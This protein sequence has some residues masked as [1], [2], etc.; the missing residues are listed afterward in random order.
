[1]LQALTSSLGE[2]MRRP[3]VNIS[4]TK[5]QVEGIQQIHLNTGRVWGKTYTIPAARYS[6]PLTWCCPLS[7]TRHDQ[8]LGQHQEDSRLASLSLVGLNFPQFKESI[9][10]WTKP[11]H[12]KLKKKTFNDMK[13]HDVKLIESIKLKK[14]TEG[15]MLLMKACLWYC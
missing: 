7:W 5:S 12:P 6:N 14:Y 1:M 15:V 4:D 8:V 9:N 10:K 11:K 3:S 13:L 2:R